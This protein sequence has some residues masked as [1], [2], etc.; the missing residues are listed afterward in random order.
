MIH[1]PYIHCKLS[2]LDNRG[3]MMLDMK[4]K[5]QSDK[6]CLENFD[7]KFLHIEPNYYKINQASRNNYITQRRL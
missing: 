2:R 6:Y 3:P 1:K 4:V 7:Q 5:E